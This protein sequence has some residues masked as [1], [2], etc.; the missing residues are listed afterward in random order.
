MRRTPA[1]AFLLV[2]VFIDMLG[3]GLIVPIAPPLLIAITGHPSSAAHWAG[4]I[5]ASFGVLQFLAAPLLGRLAD[6]YGRRPV[7]IP[8][9]TF[10]GLDYLA[11]ALANRPVT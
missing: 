9:L 1:L 10:L 4:V 3:L 2:S 11:H 8:A 7:L 5:D 6:R